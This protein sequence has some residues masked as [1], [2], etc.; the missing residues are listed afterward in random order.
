[1]LKTKWS[2]LNPLQIGKFA[3]YIVGMEFTKYKNL[4]VF[5]AEVDDKGID[6]VVR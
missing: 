1:M 4:S 2:D 3:E 5:T 6:M